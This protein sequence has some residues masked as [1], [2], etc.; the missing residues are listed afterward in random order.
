MNGIVNKL[1][2]LGIGGEDKINSKWPSMTPDPSIEKTLKK[3]KHA[4]QQAQR[5]DG[6][7]KQFQAWT[8]HKEND[9]PDKGGKKKR[10][11]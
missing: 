4:N 8:P 7:R 1:P 6:F 10:K 11:R 2:F 3:L 9:N 5:W